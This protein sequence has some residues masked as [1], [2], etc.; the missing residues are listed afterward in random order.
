M[1]K[2][3][4]RII[5]PL[6]VIVSGVILWQLFLKTGADR[7]RLRL[8][9]NIDVTQVDMAFKISGR[10]N[11]RL[12]DEGNHVVQGQRLGA[13]DDTDQQ[14]QLQKA[15]ADADYAASILAELMAGS[16][17][18]EIQRAEAKVRQ[19]RFALSEL[20]NGS[21]TQEIA[22]AEAGLNQ[23]EASQRSADSELSLA[24]K[25]FARYEAVF[26]EGGISRQA[27]ETYRTRLVKAQNAAQVADFQRKAADERLSLRREGSRKE[28]IRQ[29][30]S[31]LAQAEAELAL[32]K[33]GP[34]KETIDQARA[35][36][37]AALAALAVARQQIADTELFAPFDGVVLSTS[38]EAGS[39][40]NPGST[41]L[42][43]GDIRNAWLRGFVAEAD[44]GRLR[45]GQSA[46]VSIDAYPERT[47]NGRVSFI[48]SAAEFTPRSVQ[49]DKERTNL[50]YR[51]KIQLENE[52]GV[53]K[54]GMPADAVIE[55]AP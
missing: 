55:V 48:S 45:L 25:D 42:T 10:L 24:R 21:R 18:E 53:L 32:I 46:V 23:A 40:L 37:D 35:K 44:L 19:A 43:I 49:T 29:A 11:Q 1:L 36:K 5:I 34:R 4:L 3:R 13:L 51:L 16:R 39:Y 54:P 8:S 9:G 38:A 52:D 7:D 17:P 22:E 41:V 2:K 47:W 14:I 50:V 27:F 30:R 20:L 12:V 26:K 33:A 31:V 6:V 28:R 15:A